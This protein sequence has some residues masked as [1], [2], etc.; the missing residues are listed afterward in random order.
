MEIKTNKYKLIVYIY[1]NIN[2]TKNE[3]EIGK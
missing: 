1:L 2:V 3:K